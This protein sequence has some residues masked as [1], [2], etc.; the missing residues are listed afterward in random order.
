LN[1]N[2]KISIVKPYGEVDLLLPKDFSLPS[3]EPNAV[4]TFES[5]IA[6]SFNVGLRVPVEGNEKAFDNCHLDNLN[7]APDGEFRKRSFEAKVYNYTGV[8]FLG[9]I[10]VDN[11]VKSISGDEFDINFIANIYA[12][13]IDGKTIRDVMDEM[14][15]IGS[16]NDYDVANTATALSQQFWPN[17]IMA[18]PTMGAEGRTSQ[19]L[20]IYDNDLGRFFVNTA[21]T[22]YSLAPQIFLLEVLKRC[23]THFG[24]TVIGTVFDSERLKKKL[25]G[26]LFTLDVYGF[27]YD[28]K[29]RLGVDLDLEGTV[30]PS[31]EELIY[32]FMDTP[33]VLPSDTPYQAPFGDFFYLNVDFYFGETVS[34][35]LIVTMTNDTIGGNVSITPEAN[36]FVSLRLQRLIYSGDFKGVKITVPSG[37]TCQIKAQTTLRFMPVSFPGSSQPETRIKAEFRKQ[38]N[39]KNCVPAIDIGV[40]LQNL[41]KLYGIA[42]NVDPVMR[43]AEVYFADEQLNSAVIEIKTDDVSDERKID[44]GEPVKLVYSFENAKTEF[45]SEYVYLGEFESLEAM[46]GVVQSGIGTST[47]PIDPNAPVLYDQKRYALIKNLNSYY[48]NEDGTWKMSGVGYG[49]WTYGEGAEQDVQIGVS[50]LPMKYTEWQEKKYTVCQFPEKI[51]K[52]SKDKTVYDKTWPLYIFNF[53]GFLDSQRAPG[54]YF[55]ASSSEYDADGNDTG[56]DSMRM[57]IGTNEIQGAWLRKWFDMWRNPERLSMQVFWSHRFGQ[58]SNFKKRFLINGVRYLLSSVKVKNE[59]LDNPAELELVRI[60]ES[61]PTPVVSQG[62]QNNQF[63]FTINTAYQAAPYTLLL[64]VGRRYAEPPWP[65]TNW[66][67]D[68]GDGTSE[69]WGQSLNDNQY[70]QHTYENGGEYTVVIT[71]Y[72]LRLETIELMAGNFMVTSI[73]QIPYSTVSQQVILGYVMFS[74][75]RRLN[76]IGR[77][78]E[79]VDALFLYEC[80][81]SSQTVDTIL[82]DLANNNLYGGVVRLDGQDPPQPPFGQ[83]VID[84]NTL[85]ART[86][87]VFTD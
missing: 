32:E 63:V 15:G 56:I 21:N 17:S 27:Q 11:V 77:I 30:F 72:D 66:A 86:W 78:P 54:Q 82:S 36:G 65:I 37:Q 2:F 69:G 49:K 31:W 51:D 41:K 1:R 70:M 4:L 59:F 83:G 7:I 26:G 74:G 28:A 60:K 25:I 14:Y 19:L 44:V 71:D 6:S 29:Y 39:L 22:E 46:L 10:E 68:W 40:F 62:Y 55:Q 24:Y 5:A 67:I 20:N 81:L 61:F 85:L 79:Q 57:G 48:I 73:I 38:F 33:S 34:N 58:I 64:T 9:V 53:L 52:I 13:E 8:R 75:C 87:D 76:T 3:T 84:A 50:V 45:D 47:G 23:F 80:N 12:T 35:S 16:E 43:M 42:F 18:F